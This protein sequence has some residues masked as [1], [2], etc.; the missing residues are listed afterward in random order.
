MPSSADINDFVAGGYRE[1]LRD[2]SRS[3]LEAATEDKKVLLYVNVYPEEFD[4]IEYYFTDH[5]QDAGFQST[6]FSGAPVGWM[7]D[8]VTIN[9]L[10]Q[11]DRINLLTGEATRINLYKFPVV[12]NRIGLIYSETYDAIQDNC[13][14]ASLNMIQ[15]PL[16]VIRL[17]LPK[18]ETR[19]G[20][21]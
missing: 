15:T 19:S 1:N 4:Q 16:S 17:C 11:V 2:D 9:L 5:R 12:V 18:M 13:P 10:V 6:V 7:D 21:K 14:I 8:T 20:S 3:F